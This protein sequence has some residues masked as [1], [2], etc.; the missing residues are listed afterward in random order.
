MKFDKLKLYNDTIVYL[1]HPPNFKNLGLGSSSV[2]EC[3][4]SICLGPVPVMKYRQPKASK[5]AQQLKA[6]VHKAGDLEFN[7]SDQHG[8]KERTNPL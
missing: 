2:V 7:P 5:V 6:L 1:K 3:L 8:G 4:S